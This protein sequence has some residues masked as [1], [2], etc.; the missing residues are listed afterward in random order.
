M[1]V[2]ETPRLINQNNNNFWEK[3]SNNFSR[4]KSTI[5]PKEKYNLR[6]S[7]NYSTINENYFSKK[8]EYKNSTVKP[9]LK[10]TKKESRFYQRRLNRFK[11]EFKIG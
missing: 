6:V 11:N 4:I 9:E 2:V 10:L 8:I 7:N 5:Q 3:N 1:L